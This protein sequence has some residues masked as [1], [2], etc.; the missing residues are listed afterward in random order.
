MA[1][2]CWILVKAVV[3]ISVTRKMT[4]CYLTVEM[5]SD[6]GDGTHVTDSS[7][8]WEDLDNYVRHPATF[9]AI[10]GLQNS[11]RFSD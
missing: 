11:A 8:L 6:V 2:N 1:V 3:L 7:F 10:S 5:T 4:Y 9:T